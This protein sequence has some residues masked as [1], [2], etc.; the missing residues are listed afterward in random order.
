MEKKGHHPKRS[1]IACK[2]KQYKVRLRRVVADGEGK[3]V[4]D[5]R[6]RMQGRGAYLCPEKE[7]LEAALKRGS[8]HKAFRRKVDTAGVYA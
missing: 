2:R 7:C 5:R 6:Q 4:W 3:I 8:F 1:C